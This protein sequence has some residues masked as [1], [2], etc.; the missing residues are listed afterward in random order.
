MGI[1]PTLAAWEAA[2]LPLNYTRNRFDSIG[3]WNAPASRAAR[4]GCAWALALALLLHSAGAG[5]ESQDAM[6]WAFPGDPPSANGVAP[7]R[8]DHTLFHVPHSRAAYTE[9]QVSDL[10]AP[11]DWH[12]DDHPPMPEVV[13]RRMQPWPD[14]PSP[15]SSSRSRTSAAARG[16]APGMA[17]TC[18]RITCTPPSW[19]RPMPRSPRQRPIFPACA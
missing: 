10:F 4:S 7:S 9:A 16:A 8:D 13:A 19:P 1:E 3:I 5:S 14:C 15:T 6:A 2:V 12:P 11:P 17:S 18:R